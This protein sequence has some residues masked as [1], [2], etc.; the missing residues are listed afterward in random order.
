MSF[1]FLLGSGC[2]EP[3]T[4]PINPTGLDCYSS[5]AACVSTVI[6]NLPDSTSPEQLKPIDQKPTPLATKASVLPIAEPSLQPSE[7]ILFPEPTPAPY[8]PLP[9]PAAPLNVNAPVAA[10]EHQPATVNYE[11]CQALVEEVLDRIDT[12]HAP[13]IRC[14]A[15]IHYRDSVR[16]TG[17]TH[18]DSTIE[19]YFSG[20]TD[21]VVRF[22]IAH[23][24]GHFFQ[25]L[26]LVYMD[27]TI[28][29]L[30]RDADSFAK[31]LGFTFDASQGNAVDGRA[32][33]K[34]FNELSKGALVC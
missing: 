10:T 16:L 7:T 2:T 30:E 9:T 23:E 21:E 34:S 26:F 17:I 22:T 27:S 18:S 4:L 32:V 28:A 19:I 29:K 31:F 1:S 20:R 8:E 25:H 14:V 11:R 13:S 3:V 24:L 12:P 15:G 33:C 5:P 6:A